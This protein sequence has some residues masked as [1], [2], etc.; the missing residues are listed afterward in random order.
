MQCPKCT[1]TLEPLQ[2]GESNLRRCSD[3]HG[4]WCKPEQL[5][6]LQDEWMSEALVDVGNPRVGSRLNRLADIKCPE[7][8]GLMER[9]HDAEQRHVWYEECPVCGGIFLDAGEFTDLKF[10]TLLDWVRGLFARD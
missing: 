2:V 4:L 10:K 1:G 9:R 3:C 5:A 6:Q 8:H 7:G